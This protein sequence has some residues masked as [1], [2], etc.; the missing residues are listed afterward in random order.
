[1]SSALPCTHQCFG[2]RISFLVQENL[3]DF[4]VATVGSDVQRSQV[5]IGDVVHRHVVLN[6]ELN[7][8]QVIPL[9]CHVQRRQ[10]VLPTERPGA[11]GLEDAQRRETPLPGSWSVCCMKNFRS[12]ESTRNKLSMFGVR[13][14]VLT[15][16]FGACLV[17]VCRQTEKLTKHTSS[18]L[19]VASFSQYGSDKLLNFRELCEEQ[20]FVTF[21]TPAREFAGLQSCTKLTIL[22]WPVYT[23]H[24]STGQRVT[25]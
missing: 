8:V 10:T 19:N 1:M 13:M 5:V 21:N 24:D 3:G 14:G 15:P 11:D 12:P 20:H 4:V 23:R 7:T 22:M 9:C 18:A 25:Q 17:R 6:Q 2:I 16:E